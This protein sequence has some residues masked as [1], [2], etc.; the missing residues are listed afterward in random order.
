MIDGALQVNVRNVP[1]TKLRLGWPDFLDCL[2]E[3]AHMRY[4]QL[5]IREEAIQVST[6]PPFVFVLSYYW[7][8][9]EL[10]ADVLN[11]F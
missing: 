8:Y 4:P 10:L 1:A 5:N 6:P 7:F 11:L 3:L 2:C 9:Q